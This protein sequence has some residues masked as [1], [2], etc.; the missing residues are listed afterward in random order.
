[1][2]PRTF[3]SAAI[4]DVLHNATHHARLPVPLTLLPAGQP[5]FSF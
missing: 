1:M 4:A 5:A 3:F 2:K